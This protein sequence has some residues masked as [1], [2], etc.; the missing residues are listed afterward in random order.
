MEPFTEDAGVVIIDIY[1]TEPKH[2]MQVAELLSQQLMDT[3]TLYGENYGRWISGSIHISVDSTR[4]IVYE[5]FSDRRFMSSLHAERSL[6]PIELK[7]ARLAKRDRH[8]YT[9]FPFEEYTT[10]PKQ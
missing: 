7:V 9:H 8:L 6:Q 10:S 2:Q 5:R 3:K 4:V 1:T